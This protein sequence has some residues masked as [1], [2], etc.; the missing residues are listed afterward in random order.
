M[1]RS[2]SIGGGGVVGFSGLGE[3]LDDVRR[4]DVGTDQVDVVRAFDVDVAEARVRV[5]VELDEA[6]VHL[7]ALVHRSLV[8]LDDQVR[9]LHSFRELQQQQQQGRCYGRPWKENGLK[10]RPVPG[11]AVLR[12][13]RTARE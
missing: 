11:R 2:A 6:L 5:A 3:E 7:P 8:G 1:Y 13:S 10:K 12:C 9:T 4:H